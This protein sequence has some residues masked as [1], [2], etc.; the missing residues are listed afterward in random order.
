MTK[1]LLHSKSGMIVSGIIAIVFIFLSSLIW[2]VGALILN[3][4][5]DAFMPWFAISNPRAYIVSQQA[6]TAYAIS[7]VITDILLLV[8]WGL[9]S[10]KRES[11]ESPGQTYYG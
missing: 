3:K 5:F 6:M 1:K 7:I 9:S 8:W 11:Q 10:Q 2:L 4:T